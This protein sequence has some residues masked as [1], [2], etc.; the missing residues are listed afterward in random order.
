VTRR[1]DALAMSSCRRRTSLIWSIRCSH[2]D[3][4]RYGLVLR[5][6]VKACALLSGRP[7][8]V[9]GNSAAGTRSHSTLGITRVAARL[10][11]TESTSRNSSQ[12]HQLVPAA[13]SVGYADDHLVVAHV[14]RVDPMKDQETFL[15]AMAQLPDLKAL[16]VGNGSDTCGDAA[17]GSVAGMM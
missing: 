1:L 10:S 12:T 3:P 4:S 16:M 5:L 15:A 9:T 8:V 13:P 17:C 6:I 7:D 11:S 2:L 14:A